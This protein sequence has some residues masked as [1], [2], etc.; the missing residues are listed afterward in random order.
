MTTRQFSFSEAPEPH[1]ARTREILKKHPEIKTLYGPNR[2]TLFFIIGLV[3]LQGF[4]AW[5]I[6][7][8]EWP[9]W[10]WLALAYGFGAFVNHALFTLT[11]ECSHHLISKNRTVNLI[12]GILCDLPQVVPSS[13]SFKRYHL[14]H[15]SFQ[16]AYDLDADIPSHWEARLIGN[17]FLFKAIWLLL[18]P[19]FQ[20]MRPPRMK[21][22]TFM[23][24]WTLINWGTIFAVDFL[25]IWFLGWGSFI[26]LFASFFFSVG[27]HPLGARWIQEHFIKVGEQETYS[28]YGPFNYIAFNIGHHNEHHDFPGI[29][30]NRIHK[31]R[32]MAPEY[33]NNLHY[34]TSWTGLLFK[35]IFDPK[36]SLHSRIL[37][38]NKGGLRVKAARD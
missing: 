12:G 18:F 17:F 31:V 13:V 1:K 15:H 36:I 7:Y 14:K 33:Y 6:S 8:K 27:L 9:W 21:S 28:Y 32:E 3:A 30:W 2:S 25:V 10:A 38:E 16:G 29:P 11:H 26:Y 34:H 23:S 22:L 35:F 37:R 24:T 5:W 20:I 4:A 19:V